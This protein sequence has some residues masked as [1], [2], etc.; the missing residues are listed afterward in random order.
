MTANCKYSPSSSPMHGNDR[1]NH[2]RGKD[3]K[4]KFRLTC[5]E[6]NKQLE[7]KLQNS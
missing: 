3:I 5:C 7:M 1:H 4:N 2:G 6:V